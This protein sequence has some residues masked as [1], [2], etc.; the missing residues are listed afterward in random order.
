MNRGD[1]TLAENLR[2][3]ALVGGIQTALYLTLNHHPPFPS[4]ELPLTVVDRAV[5]FWTWTVWL[6]LMLLSCD[7]LLPLLIRRRA[8]MPRLIVAHL[9][10]MSLA[11]LTFLFLPTRYPRPAPPDGDNVHA[12][13]YRLLTDLDSPECCFPSGHIIVPVLGCWAVW[14]DGNRWR[15]W[16]AALLC[17]LAPSILTTKQHYF[18]DLIGGLA[19]AAIG[20]SIA[21]VVFGQDA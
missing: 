12:I 6:Y 4:R 5:P 19:A 7:L 14:R 11:F 9:S 16:L 17:V 10:A 13:V 21:T 20:V 18:W 1:R 2:L 15:G 8:V 3:V